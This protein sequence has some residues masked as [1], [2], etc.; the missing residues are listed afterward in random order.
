MMSTAIIPIDGEG[1][2]RHRARKAAIECEPGVASASVGQSG[3]GRPLRMCRMA[4]SKQCACGAS[5]P[6]ATW[7]PT[8]VRRTCAALRSG[9][10]CF[11]RRRSMAARAIPPLG[12]DHGIPDVDLGEARLL[13]PPGGGK[14]PELGA[15]LGTRAVVEHGATAPILRCASGCAPPRERGIDQSNRSI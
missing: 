1:G 15:P 11:R 4:T 14:R 6:S 3:G 12:S 8:P 10:H 13:A 5:Q 9:T 2:S 7:M